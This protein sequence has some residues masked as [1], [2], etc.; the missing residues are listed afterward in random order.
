[1]RQTYGA[2]VIT[3]T[4][5]LGQERDLEA[6]RDQALAAGAARAHVVDRREAFARDFLLPALKADADLPSPSWADLAWPLL[7]QTLV[8]VAAIEQASAVAHG[9][10]AASRGGTQIASAVRALG[11][12]L[13]VIAAGPPA[14]DDSPAAATD[15]VPRG[16]AGGPDEPAGVDV[17]FARGVP[18]VLNGI[19]MPLE[20]LLASLNTIAGAY[21]SSR[22]SL[23]D[24]GFAVGPV[25]SV[26]AMVVLQAAHLALRRLVTDERLG[27][28]CEVVG[29][30]YGAIVA[31]GLWFSPMRRALDGFTDEVQA[32]VTGSVRLRL[33]AGGL[34]QVS[35]TSPFTRPSAARR[36]QDART[37]EGQS[38][39]L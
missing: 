25:S 14:M 9:C 38:I 37:A 8:D 17:A 18:T 28:L 33:F 21:G 3:V 26:P 35:V 39:A 34:E 20:E 22:P 29:R 24:S 27:T 2:D 23:D 7:A 36:P 10:A 31:D 32:R 4:V 5:D 30:Q 6:V 16:A 1:L 15:L 12:D 11:P 19:E 13:I